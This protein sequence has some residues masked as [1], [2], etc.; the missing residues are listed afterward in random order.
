MLLNDLCVVLLYSESL[1]VCNSPLGWRPAARI[2]Q[3]SGFGSTSYPCGGH[4]PCWR[5]EE[6]INKGK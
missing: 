5:R 6:N 1:V 4:M 3:G 2:I